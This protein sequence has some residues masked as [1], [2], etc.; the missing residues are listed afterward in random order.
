[1]VQQRS[2]AN[3]LE[4][5]RRKR[6]E[7]DVRRKQNGY[8]IHKTSAVIEIADAKAFGVGIDMLSGAPQQ[9]FHCGVITSL[10]IAC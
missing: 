9:S 10:E 1:M 5:S 4:I 7:E 3:H 8:L 6:S 2:V